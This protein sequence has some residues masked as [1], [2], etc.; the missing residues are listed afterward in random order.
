MLVVVAIVLGL[1]I[2]TVPVALKMTEGRRL[3]DGVSSVQAALGGARDRAASRGVSVGVRFIP[4]ESNP[5]LCRSF[6]FV[7]SADA[8]SLGSVRVMESDPAGAPGVFD[9]I[10]LIGANV[11][12]FRQLPMDSAGRYTGTIRLGRAGAGYRF[13]TTEQALTSGASSF[14]T[15]N[16][17]LYLLT[18]FTTVVPSGTYPYTSGGSPASRTPTEAQLDGYNGSGVFV[19]GTTPNYIEYVGFGVE[20]EVPVETVPMEDSD[21][22]RLPAGVVIDLGQ[23]H[24]ADPN[25]ID[26]PDFRLSRLSPNSQGNWELVIS[27][28]GQAKEFNV[29]TVND[30]M[31]LTTIWVREEGASMGVNPQ[32]STGFVASQKQVR[33]ND[34]GNHRLVVFNRLTG[35]ISV[36]SPV[37]AD[38]NGDG[39]FDFERYFDNV[40]DP[41][42]GS[43]S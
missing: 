9:R 19:A 23:L 34:Q 10:V 33:T 11:N 21:P 40:S 28:T 4:E 12:D 22:I 24:G 37:F 35:Q 29:L 27:T 7:R 36:V 41:T 18:P 32:G 31:V 3:N 15:G 39:F 8:I 1:A 20:Y 2:A 16:P 25:L 14:P 13:Y 30:F 6:I 42:A 17:S 43:G 26:R 5:E 38:S